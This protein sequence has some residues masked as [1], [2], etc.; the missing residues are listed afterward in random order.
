MWKNETGKCESIGYGIFVLEI[1]SWRNKST[2]DRQIA[3]RIFVT[4][5]LENLYYT[6]KRYKSIRYFSKFFLFFISKFYSTT[7]IFDAPNVYG[8]K[9]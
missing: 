3:L 6:Y 1:G 8:L 2:F 9:K 4:T 7:L 5:R